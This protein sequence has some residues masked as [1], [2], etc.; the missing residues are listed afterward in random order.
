LASIGLRVA[1]PTPSTKAKRAA[2]F[3]LLRFSACGGQRFIRTT[4]TSSPSCCCALAPKVKPRVARSQRV[5]IALSSLSPFPIGRPF[6]LFSSPTEYQRVGEFCYSLPSVKTFA[7][8]VPD[9]REP[10]QRNVYCYASTSASR[11]TF[12]NISSTLFIR[13]SHCCAVDAVT[14]ASHG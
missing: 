8:F 11:R 7:P 14:L 9:R 4:F 6:R 5:R 3:W 12:Q 2:L 13:D 1:W 10:R